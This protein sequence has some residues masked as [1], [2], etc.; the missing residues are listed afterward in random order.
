MQRSQPPLQRQMLLQHPRHRLLR[1]NLRQHLLLLPRSLQL[2][3]QIFLYL[4]NQRNQ[5]PLQRENGKA[6]AVS[7]PRANE[8][9]ARAVGRV[10][11]AAAGKASLVASNLRESVPKG[12]AA[13]RV[14]PAAVGKAS[15]VVS[16]LRESVPRVMARAA[17]K[18]SPAASSPGVNG[19]AR[20][21]ASNLVASAQKDRASDRVQRALAVDSDQGAKATRCHRR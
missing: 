19:R 10:S 12:R 14:S 9:K 11:P 5:P 21:A 3:R 4:Q 15:L 7:S 2:L 16:S 1:L 6:R 18:A 17:G 8:P 13:G 20:V